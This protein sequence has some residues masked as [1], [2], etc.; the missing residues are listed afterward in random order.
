[1]SPSRFGSAMYSLAGD[2]PQQTMDF[3]SGLPGRLIPSAS[4][5]AFS[6]W[7]AK[8]PDEA[9]AWAKELPV[10]GPRR[11]HFVEEIRG[12]FIHS[13]EQS[14]AKLNSMPPI[15]KELYRAD[16]ASLLQEGSE[17]IND[18]GN[19]VELAKLLEDTAD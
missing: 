16:I 4:A 1:M 11:A 18:N 15:M 14:V 12:A 17:M 2:D 8:S 5:S 13:H 9:I 10:N 6:I 7:H 19:K 3:V